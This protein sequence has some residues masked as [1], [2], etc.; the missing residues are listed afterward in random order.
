[1]D[2][3]NHDWE[4]PFFVL[5]GAFGVGVIILWLVDVWYTKET[6]KPAS[7]RIREQR[8]R[9]EAPLTKAQYRFRFFLYCTV[10]T[11]F[12]AVALFSQEF[13]GWRRSR[14][15]AYAVAFS[16]AL[17]DLIRKRNHQGFADG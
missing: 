2:L 12:L 4:L 13:R 16:W 14:P 6:G 1:M 3:Q 7:E 17:I 15:I 10:L 9:A 8:E 5:V 11:I